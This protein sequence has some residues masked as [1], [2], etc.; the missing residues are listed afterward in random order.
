MIL[1]W[2]LGDKSKKERLWFNSDAVLCHVDKG[3][4]MCVFVKLQQAG[5]IWK[6]GTTVQELSL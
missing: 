2:H 4:N 1:M 6:E 5:V 3:S